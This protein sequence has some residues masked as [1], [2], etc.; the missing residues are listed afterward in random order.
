MYRGPFGVS[1]CNWNG[2]LCSL[3]FL[4]FWRSRSH[5]ASVTYRILQRMCT[6]TLLFYLGVSER[7]LLGRWIKSERFLFPTDWRKWDD[8]R[9]HWKLEASTAALYICL[10]AFAWKRRYIIN[11]MILQVYR[12]FAVK[13][14][15]RGRLR[16]WQK[17]FSSVHDACCR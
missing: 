10:W 13:R 6:G 12:V 15:K 9:N 4:W 1:S 14:K 11:G 3:V 5:S 2:L 17:E 7:V 8:E 16:S